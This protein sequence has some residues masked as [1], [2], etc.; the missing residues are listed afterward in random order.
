M[1][2][3]INSEKG[4]IVAK[5]L[6]N[7]FS[8]EGIL[9]HNEMP[10]DILPQGVERSS[11]E[12]LLFITL[13]VSIDYLRDANQLWESSRKTFE[14]NETNYLFKPEEV[15]KTPLDQI[16]TDMQKYGLSKKH[17]KDSF[18]WRTIA[19]TFYKKWDGNP[20][21]FIE[22]CN[23]DSL[24]ILKRLQNDTHGKKLNDFPYLRGPKIGPL[25]VRMLRDNLKYS[26]LKN[27][28]KVPIPV[29]RHVAKASL[30]TGVITGEYDGNLNEL[31]KHVRT[32]WFESVKGLKI[33]K[34]DMIALDVDEPLWHLSKYGCTHRDKNG[35]CSVFNQCEAKEFC[36]K[37]K[38]SLN[39]NEV[40]L[41]T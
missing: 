36:I 37:G 11:L 29:D 5:H 3:N 24:T 32:A 31:F 14:D 18:I 13:S 15:L 28:D 23:W 7:S 20:L 38:I 21:N 27:L 10:E 4:K 6:F 8:N 25:W 17:N 2:I 33:G 22:D 1:S 34:Q 40:I 35:K 19:I 16:K 41:R 26:Q 9:G 39:E 12:H 30:T